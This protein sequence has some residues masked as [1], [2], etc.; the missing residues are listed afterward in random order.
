MTAVAGPGLIGTDERR[1][2]AEV[3]GFYLRGD[4]VRSELMTIDL[5]GRRGAVASHEQLRSELANKT[6]PATGRRIYD[7][8]RRRRRFQDQ[9]EWPI[10]WQIVLVRACL[11][12]AREGV[13]RCS[14][15]S[16][17]PTCSVGVEAAAP[18]IAC[19]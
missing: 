11:S 17:R 6:S 14:A 16:T 7:E 1:A 2:L 9:V 5:A 18:G 4:Q 13:G 10:E 15:W 19:W 3:S 8:H 12:R